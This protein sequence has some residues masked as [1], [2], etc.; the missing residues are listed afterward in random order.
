MGA[1]TGDGLVELRGRYLSLFT[2]QAKSLVFA[3]KAV[4]GSKKLGVEQTG[5]L[6]TYWQRLQSRRGAGPSLQ[7][8]LRVCLQAHSRPAAGASALET[9]LSGRV[10]QASWVARRSLAP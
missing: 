9:G 2:V 3:R 1:G 4:R 7:E 10:L 5:V 8:Q 6:L